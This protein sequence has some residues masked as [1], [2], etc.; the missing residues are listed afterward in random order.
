MVGRMSGQRTHCSLRDCN[1]S[2]HR[3]A[4]MVVSNW[5]WDS[6]SDLKSQC[7]KATSKLRF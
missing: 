4:T 7:D 1:T 6:L 2:H 3:K 5:V